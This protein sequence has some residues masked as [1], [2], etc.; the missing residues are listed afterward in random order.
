MYLAIYLG[1]I[2]FFAFLAFGIDKHKA[3]KG[4]FRIS[5]RRLLSL[6]L[7]GGSVGALFGMYLFHH[8]TKVN[9]FRIGIP[10]ILILQIA[11][12]ALAYYLT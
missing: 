6:A 5:E 9:K 12:V 10:C 2:S 11:I 4:K 7:I 3:K 8:K 1:V